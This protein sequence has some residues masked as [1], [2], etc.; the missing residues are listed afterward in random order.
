MI[1]V[2]L[3][4]ANQKKTA[5]QAAFSYLNFV[6]Y[7]AAMYIVTSNPNLKSVAVGFVHIIFSRLFD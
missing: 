6:D 5:K 7:L 4:Y 2:F 1:L 3:P